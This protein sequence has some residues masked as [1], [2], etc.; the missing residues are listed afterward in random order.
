MSWRDTLGVS[1]STHEP[2]THNTHDAHKCP[3]PANSA[4]SADSAYSKPGQELPSLSL[5]WLRRQGCHALPDDLDFIRRFLP[6]AATGRAAILRAYVAAWLAAMEREPLP[7]RK[8]NRGRFTANTR[9]REG[10]L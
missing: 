7:H 1:L 10:K 6:A 9:L 8:E 3:E 5:D 2:L 4:D